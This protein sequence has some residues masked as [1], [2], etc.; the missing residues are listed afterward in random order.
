V[1]TLININCM[2]CDE[3]YHIIVSMKHPTIQFCP[4]CGEEITESD[5]NLNRDDE[6]LEELYDKYGI[7]DVE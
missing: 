4:L 3:K 2:S 6:L 7:D 1:G 5:C